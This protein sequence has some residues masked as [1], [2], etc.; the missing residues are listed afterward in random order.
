MRAPFEIAAD[1]ERDALFVIGEGVTKRPPELLEPRLRADDRVERVKY[2]PPHIVV[3][4][5]L[6]DGHCVFDGAIGDLG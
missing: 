6:D 2:L 4:I 1:N 5:A 3:T